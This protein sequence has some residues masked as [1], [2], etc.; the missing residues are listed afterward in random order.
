MKPFLNTEISLFS[1]R[2][3]K[4]HLGSI[5]YLKYICHRAKISVNF[6]TVFWKI[7][8]SYLQALPQAVASFVRNCQ[9]I[10]FQETV[11]LTGQISWY[12]NHQRA[13]LKFIQQYYK[14]LAPHGKP[15]WRCLLKQAYNVELSYLDRNSHQWLSFVYDIMKWCDMEDYFPDLSKSSASFIANKITK[16]LKDRFMKFWRRTVWSGIRNTNA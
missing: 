5:S 11:G 4:L 8:N 7:Y 13:S 3:N 10:F 12:V 15:W 6:G 1:C 16:I 9:V 14:I 2:A